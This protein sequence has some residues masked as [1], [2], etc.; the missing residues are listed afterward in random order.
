MT[1]TTGDHPRGREPV[2]VALIHHYD[3]VVGGVARMFDGYA[4]RVVVADTP[5]APVDI[6]L[7]DAFA[8]PSTSHADFRG[9]IASPRAAKVVVHTWNFDPR[10]I[11]DALDNGAAGYLSKALPA[12]DLVAAL[13]RIHDGEVVVSDPP[14]PGRLTVGADWPGRV[15]GL[16]E[17]EAEVLALI[18]QGHSN[19]DIAEQL[20]LSLNTVKTYIRSAYRKIGARRRVGAVLWGMEHGFAPDRS[21]IDEWSVRRTDRRTWGERH[22]G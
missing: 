6:A 4:D 8:R 2:T 7:Y 1:T 11:S 13:E 16:S 12:R 18:V 20:F 21:R 5:G 9:L 19:L 22:T 17:R 3:V 15:E 10:P 14:R